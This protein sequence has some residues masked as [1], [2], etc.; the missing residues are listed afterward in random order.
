MLDFV[1]IVIKLIS[2]DDDK[3][4]R[5]KKKKNVVLF[6]ITFLQYPLQ[7][8]TVSHNFQPFQSITQ[9]FISLFLVMDFLIKKKFI[10]NIFYIPSP[11]KLFSISF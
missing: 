1:N 9:Q 6:S 10:E 3:F 5:G 4:F 2:I 7:V 11:L 8:H